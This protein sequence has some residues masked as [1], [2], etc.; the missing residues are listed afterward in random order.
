VKLFLPI[1]PCLPANPYALGG[2]F[3]LG[4]VYVEHGSLGYSVGQSFRNYFFYRTEGR[5]KI[6]IPRIIAQR[7]TNGRNPLDTCF[8]RGTHGTGIDNVYGGVGTVIDAANTNIGLSVQ[9]HA[10]GQFHTIS[11]RATT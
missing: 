5:P 1:P 10:K 2:G 6:G 3:G 7:K 4:N 8:D 11:G 9:N